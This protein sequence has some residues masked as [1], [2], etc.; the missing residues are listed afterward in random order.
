VKELKDRR[1]EELRSCGSE[2]LKSCGANELEI[3]VVSATQQAKELK[4]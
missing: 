3:G 2:E 1:A 4:Q